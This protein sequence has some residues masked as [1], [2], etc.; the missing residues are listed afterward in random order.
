VLVLVSLVLFALVVSACGSSSKSSS[1]SATTTPP[2]TAGGAAKVTDSITVSA[3]AS[4]NKAFKKIG[5]DFQAANPGATVKF[6]FDSSSV[7]VTQ[8][9]GGA[10]ADVFASADQTNMTKLTSAGKIDGTPVV[11]AKNKLEIATKPGNPKHITGLSSLETAGIIALCAK[12]APCGKYADAALKAANVT[13]PESKITRGQ[14]ATATLGQVTQGDAVAAIVYV[15]DV[16]GAGSAVD[17]V[18]IPDNQNQIAIYPIGVL[19]DASNAATAK[20][21][22]DYVSSPAGQSVLQSYGFLPPS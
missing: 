5:E 8:I 16:K 21:F 3:A 1:T 17:G 13:I 11:F 12:E 10:P 15:T 4:L 20:A 9:N 14:N 22:A 7:L 19:K 6:N 18:S 2:T